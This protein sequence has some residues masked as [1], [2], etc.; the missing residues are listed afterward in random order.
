MPSPLIKIKHLNSQDAGFK[1]TLLSSLSLPMADDEAIDAAVLKILAAVNAKGDEA[2]LELT[3]RFDRLN[4]AN[5]SDLEIL[6]KDLEQAYL[7]LATP[8]KDALDIAAQNRRYWRPQPHLWLWS[9]G[10]VQTSLAECAIQP[11]NSLLP[12]MRTGKPSRPRWHPAPILALRWT[13]G[14][15]SAWS[16]IPK[17]V[18]APSKYRYLPRR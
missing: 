16:D 15:R 1:E 13:A 17:P 11:T 14:F 3:E 7:T 18:N 6:R 8:Q 10:N 4:V 9:I 12:A 2:V 5:V